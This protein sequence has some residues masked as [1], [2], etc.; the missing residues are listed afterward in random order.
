MK[1]LKSSLILFVLLF[2][3]S[4]F[5]YANLDIPEV[6]LASDKAGLEIDLTRSAIERQKYVHKILDDPTTTNDESNDQPLSY[7]GTETVIACK[8]SKD[9]CY[10]VDALVENDTVIEIYFVKGGRLYF[11]PRPCAPHTNCDIQSQNNDY[12]KIKRNVFQ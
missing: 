10:T 9:K 12:W 2:G 6:K 11:H 3:I 7:F 4:H 8:Q 5:S 1:T